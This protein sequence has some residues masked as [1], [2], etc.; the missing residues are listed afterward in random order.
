MN[1]FNMTKKLSVLLISALFIFSG[2]NNQVKLDNLD[3]KAAGDDE[4]TVKLSF[5][6]SS[7]EINPVAENTDLQNIVLKGK[8]SSEKTMTTL[9]TWT[10]YS[11]VNS[12]SVTLKTTEWDF[13]VTAESHK[14]GVD[15]YYKGSLENFAITKTTETIP[16]VL[17]VENYKDN[18]TTGTGAFEINLSLAKDCIN[19][20]NL[21]AEDNIDF[22][23]NVKVRLLDGNDL[24]KTCTGYDYEDITA[25]KDISDY[26]FQKYSYSL[27]NLTP[28]QYFVEFT[29]TILKSNYKWID[30]VNVVAN[31]TTKGDS[32]PN[33]VPVGI[34]F[35]NDRASLETF[36][37]GNN[38][39]Y[40]VLICDINIGSSEVK[41]TSTN[42]ITLDLNGNTISGTNRLFNIQEKAKLNIT[43]SRKIKKS[44]LTTTAYSAFIYNCGELSINNVAFE[45]IIQYGLENHGIITSITNTDFYYSDNA[46]TH[47][48]IFNYNQIDLIENAYF[49]SKIF[50]RNN[51]EYGIISNYGTTSD[52]KDIL[53][54][55]G[56]IK[57][58]KFEIEGYN[59]YSIYLRA[60][61]SVDA[62]ENC[63]FV[64]NLINGD[65][66]YAYPIYISPYSYEA[67]P[68][69]LNIGKIKNI[70]IN[71]SN[72]TTG[73][74]I[75]CNGKTNI[76]TIEDID[77]DMD[78]CKYVDAL[79]FDTS[80]TTN[81]TT[82][83]SIKNI[84]FNANYSNRTYGIYN[85][86]NHFGN[87]TDFNMDVQVPDG[88]TSSDTSYGIYLSGTA[89]MG[90]ISDS[91]IDIVNYY[92]VTG[93]FVET[94][95]TIGCIKNTKVT[96]FAQDSS[97]FG[98]SLYGSIAPSSDG[99]KE[100]VDNTIVVNSIYNTYGISVGG[101]YTSIDLIKNNTIKVD[102]TRQTGNSTT[103][104]GI[105]LDNTNP[106]CTSN[107]GTIEY[108]NIELKQG[109]GSATGIY[110]N[111]YGF[112]TINNIKNCSIKIETP[113]VT[114]NNS[115]GMQLGRYTMPTVTTDISDN[116]IEIGTDTNPV[117][118]TGEL[119]GFYGIRVNLNTFKNNTITCINDNTGTVYGVYLYNVPISST[120]S[121]CN[122]ICKG[123]YYVCGVSLSTADNI[124][125]IKNINSY[126]LIRNST[127]SY[128]RAYG[129]NMTGPLQINNILCDTGK[130]CSFVAEQ[131]EVMQ[132]R[133]T[134][135]GVYCQGIYSSSSSS[136]VLTIDNIGENCI[137]EAKGY[138]SL[139]NYLPVEVI[140]AENNHGTVKT[141]PA[142]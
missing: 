6:S 4:C 69:G 138:G 129:L 141:T 51:N 15:I 120:F 82:V 29:Y 30:A 123:T 35:I 55:F 86:N 46:Y 68:N 73:Y 34:T 53:A 23:S 109:A 96:V 24:T 94:N 36:L 133:A 77:I 93:I 111:Y 90:D 70:T 1:K 108:C 5:T 49:K 122:I 18:N 103:I 37:T 134:V 72:K 99:K 128:P 10:N 71:I 11:A 104:Y 92:S 16:F 8:R 95:S 33:A 139:S 84:D 57:D 64:S 110:T 65:N 91:S 56:T 81:V 116:I 59:S 54:K 98:I 61:G 101:L 41:C 2:C 125:E 12:D 47:Y 131:D 26:D 74:G 85:R 31:Y 105:A 48:G 127:S 142:S 66:A 27:S 119:H 17:F 60:C 130:T 67:T 78:N 83:S 132:T 32:S 20:Y 9:K 107:I 100:L 63:E 126:S 89:T 97:A 39:E 38:G 19:V 43:S 7:R 62:I 45:N 40:G 87:V 14:N 58:V 3:K 140:S 112:G 79:H 135:S 115:Y 80:S 106:A 22:V 28:G 88:I 124:N 117:S 121:D 113:D 114:G 50:N 42:E 137:F 75:C 136:Y 102:G 44:V 76:E 13:E 25:T 52:G 21:S 118:I